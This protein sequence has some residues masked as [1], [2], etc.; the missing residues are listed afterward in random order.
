MSRVILAVAACAGIAA[1][2]KSPRTGAG[3]DA[4]KAKASDM[5]P[6]PS[7]PPVS[8]KR[9]S[10]HLASASGDVVV[11]AEVVSSPATI[12]RGL[13]YRTHLPPDDGMLFLMGFE[14][15]HVFWMHNTL[16][17]LDL[18]FIGKDLKVAGVVAN[19]EPRTDTHR[20]TGARSLYVL[21]VN[22]GWAAAHA[23][24]AGTVVRFDGVDAAAH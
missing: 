9:A 4:P 1:C 14:D 12:Q 3:G 20:S 7:Q 24:A 19:A 22:G 23:I 15:D 16:I 10:I 5:E 2:A 13:M 6:S 18:I 21:E 17:P 8:D 11:A